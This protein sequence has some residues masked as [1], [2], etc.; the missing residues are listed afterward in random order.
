MDP[1]SLTDMSQLLD[2]LG[3]EDAA[4]GVLRLGR[5]CF[6]G[7]GRTAFFLLLEVV[8]VGILP[9]AEAAPA[10]STLLSRR[11]RRLLVLLFSLESGL[12][13][14]WIRLNARLGPDSR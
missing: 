5:G 12:T 1:A 8:G 7:D 2:M 4:E 9:A 13:I 3:P 10:L 11:P 14:L 6:V